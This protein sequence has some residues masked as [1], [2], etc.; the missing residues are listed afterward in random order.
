MVLDISRASNGLVALPKEISQEIWQKANAT[1]VVQALSPQTELPAGGID[2]PIITSKPE[3]EWVGETDEHGVSKASFGSK[4]IRGYKM[5][6]TLP[7]SNE[8]RRDYTALYSALVEELPAAL[9]RKFDRT[10]LGF[11]TSP[12]TGFDTLAT[13]TEVTLADTYDSWLDALSVVAEN[14]EGYDLTGWALSPAGEIA[15][16][17][18]KDG[19][20]NALLIKD[21]ALQGSIGRIL[22]RDVFK[23]ANAGGTVNTK[24]VLGIAGDWA[25]TR[26]GAVEGISIRTSDQATLNIDGTPVNLWQRD[27][28]AVRAQFEVGFAVR[29]PK[30][31][32]KL[33]KTVTP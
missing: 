11:S 2:I 33:T 31:F 17:R 8:F 22:A 24:K 14:D 1:S 32:V 13:A 18:A 10:A 5:S 26:W 28:F 3:A 21:A 27:M 7:F 30:R 16:L 15:A 4:T 6:V 23:S 9:A 19:E 29:D 20:G 25:S 12:G